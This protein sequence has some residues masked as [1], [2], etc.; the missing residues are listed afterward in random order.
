[1]STKKASN[2]KKIKQIANLKFFFLSS[3]REKLKL[4]NKVALLLNIKRKCNEIVEPLIML[5]DVKC[6]F[7]YKILRLGQHLVGKC[8]FIRP[9][10]YFTS[11][12]NKKNFTYMPILCSF[13]M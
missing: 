9:V 7:L 5:K 2:L 8:S 3:Q 12:L 13:S 4:Y 11:Q 1:M 6:S 10:K